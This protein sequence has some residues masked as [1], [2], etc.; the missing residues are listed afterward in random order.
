[1]DFSKPSSLAFYFCKVKKLVNEING[2]LTKE[3]VLELRQRQT[4]NSILLYVFSTVFVC[5][6]SFSQKRIELQPITWNTLF[7]IILLFA[8]INAVTRSFD[9]ESREEFYL[10]YCLV[11]PQAIIIAKIIY[12]T[13]LLIV[14]ALLALL[15]YSL[16]LGNPVKDLPLFLLNVILGAAG[17]AGSLTMVAG[18]ASKTNNSAALTAILG[19]PVVLPIILMLIKLSK[20][21][22][23]GLARSA[24]YDE[25]M[26]ILAIDMIVI[27][28]SYILFPYLWRSI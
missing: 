13:L 23:D 16:V 28:V 9:R 4:I 3:I 15:V 14:M 8:A 27:T 26:V 10:Y 12:N 22:M 25:L 6:L 7:W 21:A 24:S 20:N 19:F 18:I 1:M 17:F 5:Y 2:L 11:S